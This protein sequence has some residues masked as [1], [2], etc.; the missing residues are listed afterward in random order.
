M[1]IT[2]STHT[3]TGIMVGNALQVSVRGHAP[4]H[5]IYDSVVQLTVEK[6]LLVQ[7]GG[8]LCEDGAHAFGPFLKHSEALKGRIDHSQ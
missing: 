8:H 7:V 1:N 6:L 4:K 2:C 3:H 5:I